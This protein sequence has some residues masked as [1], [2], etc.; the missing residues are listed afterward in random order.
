[1]KKLL[2]WITE[3]FL[4]GGALDNEAS[5]NLAESLPKIKTLY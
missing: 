2:G 3:F 4:K 1:M 5:E